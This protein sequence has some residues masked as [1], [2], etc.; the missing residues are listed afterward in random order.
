VSAMRPGLAKRIEK[1]RVSWYF[2]NP[3]DDFHIAENTCCIDYADIWLSKRV[4]WLSN[5]EIPHRGI[6]SYGCEDR[7]ELYSGVAR[8]RLPITGLHKGVA[9][10]SRIQWTP[11]N[12]HNSGWIENC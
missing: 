7:L 4:H 3:E 1:I 6:S 10:K 11:A 5:C 9:L 8:A 2:E 12:L